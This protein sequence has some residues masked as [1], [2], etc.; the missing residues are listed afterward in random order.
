[1]AFATEAELETYLGASVTTDQ[2]TLLL[3]IATGLIQ[4]ETGQ[5]LSAVAGDE[6][7]LRGNW[8]DR[9]W[10]PQRPVTAVSAITVDGIAAPAGDYTWTPDGCVTIDCES[11]IINAGN[12]RGYWGGPG[13]IVAVTYSH[14]FTVIPDDIKG[15]CLALAARIQSAPN[16]GAVASESLGAYSVTYSREFSGMLTAD[17][18]KILKRYRR[19]ALSVPTL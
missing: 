10:L 16:G 17:E 9:L 13:I 6:I 15:V 5:T 3:N 14:G 18:K 12:R 7:E 19:T 8:T 1:M 4:N 11:Q 2:A